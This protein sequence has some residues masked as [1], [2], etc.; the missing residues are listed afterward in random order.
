MRE[1]WKWVAIGF[2]LLGALMVL[3]YLR[4]TYLP[5]KRLDAFLRV[6]GIE[7]NRIPHGFD[8]EYVSVCW[9]VGK[10]KTMRKKAVQGG[11]IAGNIDTLH[12][13]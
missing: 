8:D 1:M 6:R 2:V 10:G 5:L 11:P 9:G 3:G 7:F 4:N 12:P 13:Q